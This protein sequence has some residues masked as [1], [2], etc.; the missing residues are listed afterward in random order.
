M[1]CLI[2][3]MTIELAKIILSLYWLSFS[4]I[5]FL[6]GCVLYLGKNNVKEKYMEGLLAAFISRVILQICSIYGYQD[7][8]TAIAVTGFAMLAWVG[9]DL[10]RKL[11]KKIE[12]DYF[13]Y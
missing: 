11:D 6:F 4:Y 2:R 5:G 1:E 7:K 13:K 10:K 8:R 9:L 3:P 12:S